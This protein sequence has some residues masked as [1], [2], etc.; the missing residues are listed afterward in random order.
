MNSFLDNFTEEEKDKKNIIGIKE[1]EYDIEKDQ[2][3]SNNKKKKIIIEVLSVLLLIVISVFIF[4]NISKVEV[5]DFNNQLSSIV[6][7]W[8]DKNNI[9]LIEE[10]QY[11]D[12]IL[13]DFI[14]NQNIK[15]GKKISKNSTFK[16]TISKGNDPSEKIK[17]PDLKN[18]TGSEIK[19][20]ID[21]NKLTSTIITEENSIKIEKGK[22]ISYAFSSATTDE[23]NFTRS[24]SL[25]IIISKGNI[26]YDKK[27]EVPNLIDK[28]KEDV[29]KW[30]TENNIIC[31]YSDVI[32]DEY[33]IGRITSQ[34]IK[35]G[36]SITTDTKMKLNVSAGKGITI[37]N[38]YGVTSENAPAVNSKL[39]IKIKLIY[40]MNIGY[41]QLISQS[42]K[43]GT[44][45]L[46]TDNKIE[47]IY[48]LGKPY[49]S[50]L[51]GTSESELAKVFYEY[52]QK[53][54]KFTYT[55]KY[56]NSEKD[57]G[58]IVW[59]SKYN[60][61]VTINENIEVH[62]SNGISGE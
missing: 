39:D 45:K 41:G 1:V 21:T 17:V 34:S 48:S 12:E 33:E 9:Q 25:E 52:N 44:R 29:I 40:N 16:I 7:K 6:K 19:E 10:E 14:I 55:V 31:N 42:V 18:M 11:D 20:W 47:L 53:G 8:A 58:T 62:V 30:C 59:A 38:F 32:S 3:Y 57:K 22:L 61:F 54:L 43:A 28:S 60:E 2:K 4:I 26:E 37:P 46:E 13:E 15:P 35:M 27:I 36:E 24:D 51:I 56:I 5:P 50:S 23:N 49:F